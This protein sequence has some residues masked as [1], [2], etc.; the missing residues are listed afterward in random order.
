MQENSPTELIR[1]YLKSY[2][3]KIAANSTGRRESER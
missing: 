2:E 3:T 1:T